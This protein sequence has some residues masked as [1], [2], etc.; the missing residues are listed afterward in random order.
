VGTS[1]IGFGGRAGIDCRHR[2]FASKA[3]V[4]AMADGRF[5]VELQVRCDDCGMLF[6]FQGPPRG[7]EVNGVRAS[8]GGLSVRLAIAPSG[9]VS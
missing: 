3:E 4:H 5:E 7:L 6:A 2:H 8:S 9:Q 1:P